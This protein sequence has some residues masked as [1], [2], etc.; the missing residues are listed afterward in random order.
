VACDGWVLISFDSCLAVLPAVSGNSQAHQLGFLDE[1]LL[2]YEQDELLK[3]VLRDRRLG[4]GTSKKS[5]LGFAGR[6]R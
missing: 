6:Q 2:C 5:N 4:P 3:C 1:V